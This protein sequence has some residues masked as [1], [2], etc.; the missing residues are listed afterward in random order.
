M[1]TPTSSSTY[2][3]ALG[4]HWLT[5]LYDLVVGATTRERTFKR[6]L[7]AQARLESHHRVLDLACGT[8]T[9]TIWAKQATPSAEITGVDSDPAVLGLAEKKRTAAG[10]QVR[11]DHALSTALPYANGQFDRILSSLFFHHLKPAE[12]HRTALE[13]FRVLKPGG[14]LH[15]ADW[16]QPANPLMR[17]L[18]I[19][20]RMLDG[21]ANTRDHANG[22]L[23][24]FFL[25]A[26]FHRVEETARFNTIY[27]T[28]A[29]YRAARP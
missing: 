29:L 9:L 14:E 17:A 18:F 19:S 22:K 12:K 20:I 11:F 4:Y 21:F 25:S 10:V 26:G 2:I 23:P 24:E 5:P 15:I 1:P 6:A 27:G 7:I 8:G 28:L 3:P 16:G 13:S